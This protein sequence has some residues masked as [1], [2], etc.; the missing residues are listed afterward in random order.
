[1]VSHGFLKGCIALYTILYG[2]VR[3]DR[4]VNFSILRLYATVD[5]ILEDLV[6]LHWGVPLI[7][8]QCCSKALLPVLQGSA[9]V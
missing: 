3:D 1:M 9:W 6:L 7:I 4:Q 2:L 5:D 8:S